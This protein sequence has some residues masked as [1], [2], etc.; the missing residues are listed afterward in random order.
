MGIYRLDEL[1]KS[2]PRLAKAG[3]KSACGKFVEL[4][5]VG[6]NSPK[7]AILNGES[8]VFLVPQS[9]ARNGK[10]TIAEPSILELTKNFAGA[11]AKWILAGFKCVSEEIYKARRAACDSCPLW[12]GAARGGWGKCQ[13]KKCGCTKYKLLLATEKCPDGKWTV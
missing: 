6:G 2:H 10:P 8:V 7:E 9:G 12:D 11:M 4:E 1:K 5:S 13:H 3:R